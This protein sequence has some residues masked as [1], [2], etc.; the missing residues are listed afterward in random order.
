M[1]LEDS[2]V[3]MSAFFQLVCALNAVPI[4]TPAAFAEVDRLVLKSTCR[5][6]GPRV[7]NTA[8]DKEEL[9]GKAAHAL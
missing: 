4:R 3:K 2:I 8:P 9:G 7:A 6:K 1:F 5:C